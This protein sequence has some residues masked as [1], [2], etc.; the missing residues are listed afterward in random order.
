M[1][2]SK[3]HVDE[4]TAAIEEL[5]RESHRSFVG[6]LATITRDCERPHEAVQEAFARAV[7]KRK[8]VRNRDAL[9]GWFW[10]IA[11]RTALELRGVREVAALDGDLDVPTLDEH[12]DRPGGDAM[13]DGR[14]ASQQLGGL[15]H[16]R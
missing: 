1:R 13:R 14:I 4:R 6:V 10:R 7:A 2:A 8:S 12:A 15:A 9:A 16:A 11:I 3:G 5:Y